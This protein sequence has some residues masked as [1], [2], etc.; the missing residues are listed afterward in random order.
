MDAVR[1]P[2]R[3]GGHCPPSLQASPPSSATLVT[4]HVIKTQSHNQNFKVA[5]Q[6]R[7]SQKSSSGE[8]F[9][10]REVDKWIFVKVPKQVALIAFC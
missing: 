2:A 7:W 3:L 1:L 4:M 5:L 6:K 9:L 8:Q 10:N